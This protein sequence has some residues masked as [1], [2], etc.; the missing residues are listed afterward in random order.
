MLNE[1]DPVI[2]GEAVIEDIDFQEEVDLDLSIP[3]NLEYIDPSDHVSLYLKQAR[4]LYIPPLTHPEEISLGTRIQKGLTIKNKE[5]PKSLINVLLTDD[6]REAYDTLVSK[7]LLLAVSFAKK[8]IG[9]GV[10]FADLLQNGNSG[11]MKAAIKYEPDR[12]WKFSTFACWWIRQSLLR[13]ISDFGK[14]IR[15]PVHYFNEV[16]KMKQIKNKL[17][18]IHRK[19]PSIDEISKATGLTVD[20]IRE[21]EI[22]SSE[23]ISLEEPIK[24]SED[25][26][27]L[28]EIIGDEN[29]LEF[30]QDVEDKDRFE[31]LKEV[32]TDCCKKRKFSKRD[33]QMIM[34]KY[35][36]VDKKEHTLDETGN[37]FNVTRE[38]VRQI[39]QN[40]LRVLRNSLVSAK[41]NL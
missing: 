26:E 23:S 28:G 25:E 36:M 18:Q 15:L 8:F 10:E 21:M 9:R 16:N 41:F 27:E 31:K 40:V 4:D 11:L 19:T 7:N 24:S 29:S 17:T 35:G 6:A 39:E 37:L 1:L 38:R 3:S 30:I 22:I 12:G 2:N 14:E 13:S 5:E 20:Y 34:Y 32:I 33:I